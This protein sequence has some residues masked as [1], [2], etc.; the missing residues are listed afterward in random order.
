MSRSNPTELAPNP[1]VKFF[2]WNGDAGH[3]FYFDKT[4]GEKG[5]KVDVKLPFTFLFLDGLVTVKGFSDQHQKGFYSNEIRDLK[6]QKLNVRMGKDTVE[7]G[8]YEEI[9]DRL[10]KIGASYTQS[11]YIAFK[12]GDK[13]VIGN[14]NF[15]GAS[16][17]P[18]IDFKNKVKGQINEKAV[19]IKSTLEGKKG[20]V[21]YQMPVFELCDVSEATNKEAVELDK[22]LQAY[23]T[24]YLSKSHS[25]SIER[26]E[27]QSVQPEI[28]Q[29][30][31]TEDEKLFMVKSES[32]D[33]DLS[34][35]ANQGMDLVEGF[36]QDDSDDLP[37]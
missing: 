23:L 14:V 5:A 15:K 27:A 2:E 13:L 21:V 12:E 32:P 3:F 7:L 34:E 36:T 31:L 30:E 19:R 37:F 11:V 25:K 9:K 35:L 6:T 1:A 17:G 26:E 29:P 20:K 16:L 22:Q 33:T 10:A 18:W 28:H 8:L 4:I 24:E